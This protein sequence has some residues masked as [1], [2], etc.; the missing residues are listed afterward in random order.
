[1]KEENG[2]KIENERSVKRKYMSNM[3]KKNNEAEMK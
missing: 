2:A 1:M 3:K